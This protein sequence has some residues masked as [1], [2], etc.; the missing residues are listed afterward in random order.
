MKQWLVLQNLAALNTMHRKMPGW[1]VTYKTPKGVE[2][3]LDYVLI[4]RKHMSFSRD[5]QANDMIH[6]GSDH[7]SFMAQSVIKAPMKKDS[8]KTRIEGSKTSTK[9][10]IKSQYDG[11]KGF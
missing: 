1:Q 3:Q 7:R 9:E 6:I 4:N 2:K 8:Q 5:A 11:R 10:S